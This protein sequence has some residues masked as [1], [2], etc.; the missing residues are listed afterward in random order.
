MERDLL[1]PMSYSYYFYYSFIHRHVNY[2]LR[3]LEVWLQCSA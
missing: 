1:F 3:L 2:W